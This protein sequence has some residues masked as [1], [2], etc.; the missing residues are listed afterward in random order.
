M[1]DFFRGIPNKNFRIAIRQ[2]RYTELLK[3]GF[4]FL[5]REEPIT[6]Y[7]LSL[8]DPDEFNINKIIEQYK[9]KIKIFHF[10]LNERKIRERKADLEKKFNENIKCIT[11]MIEEIKNRLKEIKKHDNIKNREDKISE[12]NDSKIN[13]NQISNEL[14][15]DSLSEINSNVNEFDLS[16]INNMVQELKESI[17]G[18][19][20]KEV[21]TLMDQIDILNSDL[22]YL[23]N[24]INKIQDDIFDIIDLRC[25]GEKLNTIGK[26]DKLFLCYL[27]IFEIIK[28][29]IYGCREDDYYKYKYKQITEYIKKICE[30]DEKFKEQLINIVDIV[31]NNY[32][33]IDEFQNKID[34]QETISESDVK[35][36]YALLDKNQEIVKIITSFFNPEELDINELFKQYKNI[37]ASL[38]KIRRKLYKEL[39]V[40]LKEILD[41]KINIREKIEKTKRKLLEMN[42]KIKEDYLPK[43][44]V[45][46]TD[47][48]KFGFNF[49]FDFFVILWGGTSYKEIK[50]QEDIIK[51]LDDIIKESE[52]III[53][54]NEFIGSK[55]SNL[56]S[57][58]K[59]ILLLKIEIKSLYEKLISE[60]DK[61][62]SVISTI[63]K[64]IKQKKDIN[65][66]YKL[67][68]LDEIMLRFLFCINGLNDF[69][70]KYSLEFYSNSAKSLNFIK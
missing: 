14:N 33:E 2:Y 28:D 41:N 64:L 42:Y 65:D 59:E 60:I 7:L 45:E 66:E 51:E 31:E 10:S 21:L 16:E 46:K 20:N 24:A 48:N 50:T 23:Y 43:E 70:G 27:D 29:N 6:K 17:S 47:S 13:K 68:K 25:N 4:E 3:N 19:D 22:Q 37:K 18:V 40:E 1:F 38:G 8:F 11:E 55:E 36:G 67:G 49:T 56:D 34:N 15:K 26:Y 62:K 44:N 12:E 39:K 54:S 9:K 5:K 53:E 57:D 63:T 61:E 58:K 69:V 30:K 35:N 32:E 52:N